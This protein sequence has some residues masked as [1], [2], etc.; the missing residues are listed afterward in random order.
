MDRVLGLLKEN[1]DLKYKEFNSS[2]IPTIDKEIILGVRVPIIKK[3]VSSLTDGER[4]EYLNNLS[5]KYYEEILVHR[6]IIEKIKDYDKALY[7]INKLLPYLNC[8][9]LTDGFS[10]KAFEKN[11]GK[12]LIEIKKWIKNPN[13]YIKRFAIGLLMKYYLDNNFD[14]SYLDLACNI[15]TNNDYYLEM[16]I[17]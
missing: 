13:N 15:E 3:I 7:E 17:A 12:L 9:S 8:W 14:P 5:F 16:M 1:V 10:N 4:E 11:K 6:F 2:L